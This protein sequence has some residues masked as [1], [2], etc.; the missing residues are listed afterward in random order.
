MADARSSA[1]APAAT[2]PAGA[3][4]PLRNRLFAML[5]VATVL[6]N[7]GTFMRDVASAWLVLD[8]SGSPAAVALIQAA[9]TLPVF[10]LAIPAGVLSDLLDR[11]RLLIAI[12]CALACVSATLAV[13]AATGGTNVA[14]LAA[15]TLLGGVGAALMGPVWQSIVPE[16]V[17]RGELKGAVALN[18]LGFNIARAIGPAAGGAVLAAFGAAATYGA[19]VLTYALVLVALLLWRRTPDPRDDLAEPFGGAL[20]AGLRYAR[21][22]PAVRRLLLRAG[23]FFAGASAVWALLPIVA[24]RLLG[25]GPGFY[26]L[27]LGAVGAGAVG[28]A[29]L[30]PRLR[31]RLGADGVVLAG[32]LVTAAVMAILALAPPRWLAPPILLLLGAAWIAVLTT[33]NATIQAVL[34][35]WVRGRGLALYLTVFNGAATAGSLAWGAVAEAV[36]VPATLLVAALGVAAVGAA[37]RR[38]PLPAG[39][40][41]LSPSNHW[42]EPA[43]AAPVP[44]DRGPVLISVEYR[45][46]AADRAA[47]LAV[48]R[49]LAHERR[50]DGAYAWGVAEDAAHPERV[51]EW[52]FVESWAEH[53][54]QHRRVSHAD[55]DVQTQALAFHRGPEPPAVAHFL[56][57]DG[58]P[59]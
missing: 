16:L 26:G 2:P 23:L 36:G 34:P 29:V 46:A 8:L 6:G 13:L 53:R 4:A 58:R 17:P 33:L 43:L 32:A 15:L 3:F 52:F 45:V 18:S 21:S 42:P 28:G 31:E 41:D 20:K 47:F 19:D 7:V 44:N 30:L 56:A 35:N 24:G 51:L 48:L 40:D 14:A 25:G 11:R 22:S 5:W 50:R 49:R 57:L 37:A 10:L 27:L 1:A 12:Q 55:A 9:A 38:L 59:A 54:R 39:E